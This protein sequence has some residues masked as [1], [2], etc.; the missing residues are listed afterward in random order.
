MD[1]EDSMAR[2]YFFLQRTP[3]HQ[4]NSLTSLTQVRALALRT[5]T[6]LA[7]MADQGWN[8]LTHNVLDETRPDPHLDLECLA[9]ALAVKDITSLCSIFL[10]TRVISR[11]QVCGVV[12]QNLIKLLF[13]ALNM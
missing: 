6:S 13:Q 8:S 7:H 2:A 12:R 1:W 10:T 3:D 9:P 5:V 4:R 11:N